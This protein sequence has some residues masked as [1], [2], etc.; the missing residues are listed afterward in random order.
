LLKFA[1]KDWRNKMPFGAIETRQT[2]RLIEFEPKAKNQV[3]WPGRLPEGFK[4]GSMGKGISTSVDFSIVIW[5]QYCVSNYT[6]LYTKTIAKY[7][8]FSADEQQV[9]Y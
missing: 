8:P 9:L 3:R 5:Y 7:F 6:S 1:E 2:I 4:T